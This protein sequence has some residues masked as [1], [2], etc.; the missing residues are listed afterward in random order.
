MRATATP[1]PRR[2]LAL[3]FGLLLAATSG[4]A[5]EAA[6]LEAEAKKAF[7]SGRFRE[8]AEKYARVADSAETPADRK[9]DLYLN[10]AW[11]YYIAGNSKSSRDRVP[12]CHTS[13]PQLWSGVR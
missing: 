12:P 6:R 1:A 8:A 2:A 3:V 13:R 10:S 4:L 5:Q 9:G 7:D 11:A